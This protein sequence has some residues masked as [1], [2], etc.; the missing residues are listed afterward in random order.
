VKADTLNAF[1]N[2]HDKYWTNQNVVYDYKSNLTGT[3]GLP[4]SA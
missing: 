4:V 1:K 2:R 3:G